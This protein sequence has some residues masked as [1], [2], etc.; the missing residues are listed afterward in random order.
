MGYLLDINFNLPVNWDD[1]IFIPDISNDGLFFWLFEAENLTK[2]DK[3]ISAGPVYRLSAILTLTLF[4][5][6]GGPGCSSSDG[7]IDE[8][9]LSC[10]CSDFIM[11][12]LIHVPRFQDTP[13]D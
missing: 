5:L 6:N 2:S 8:L 10:F 12:W 13:V 9:W 1:Q 7:L 11:P 4:W 3:I